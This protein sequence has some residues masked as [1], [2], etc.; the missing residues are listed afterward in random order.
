MIKVSESLL[1]VP[2]GKSDPQKVQELSDRLF[3]AYLKR[4]GKEAQVVV[5]NAREV[6][7]DVLS[8]SSKFKP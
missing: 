5:H 6:K 4:S 1:A 2:M 7:A 8:D 3:G